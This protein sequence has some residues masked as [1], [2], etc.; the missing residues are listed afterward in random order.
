MN[1]EK[2]KTA[3]ILKCMVNLN[4]ILDRIIAALDNIDK[5]L[6]RIEEKFA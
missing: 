3:E 4:S 5:R 2:D 1:G 6:K